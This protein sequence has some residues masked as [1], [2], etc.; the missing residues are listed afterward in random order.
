MAGLMDELIATLNDEL[1]I[2]RELI[3]MADFKSGIIISN[4]V[5]E[6]EKM[7]EKEQLTT[8]TL[9]RLEKKRERI[10]ADMRT[11]LGK[12]NSALK[13]D[14]LITLMAKQ[15]EAQKQL[16]SIRKELKTV[17]EKLKVLNDRNQ[18]LITESLSI[19]EYQL[20]TIRSA[21]SYIGNNYTRNAGQFDMAYAGAF[22]AR[23]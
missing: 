16:I 2:Y 18:K 22:D 23:Q 12:R 19:S 4:N 1:N 8:E 5:S 15:P 21:K 20:N 3:P 7:T 6:L 14:E 10:M 17:L 11:V 9:G 13:L